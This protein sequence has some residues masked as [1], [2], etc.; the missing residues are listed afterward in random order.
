MVNSGVKSTMAKDKHTITVWTYPT[1]KGH[2]NK[3]TKKTWKNKCPV[4]SKKKTLSLDKKYNDNGV[5]KCTCGAVYCGVSGYQVNNKKKASKKLIPATTTPNSATKVASSQ[6]QSQ[7]CGLKRAT[8]LTKAKAELNTSSTYKGTLKIPILP[9]IRLGGL[10]QLDFAEFPETKGKTLYINSIK[11]DIDNQTYT[12]ELIEGTSHFENKY[13][14]TYIITDKNGKLLTSSSKNPYKAKCSNVNVN[15]GLKDNS[16]ISKKIR[17]KG[18]KLGTVKKCYKW[19]K[20]KSAGGTG[21]WKYK[22]YGNHIVKSEKYNT[23]GE[24]SAEKCWKKKKANCCDFAWLFVML[25]NGA[26]KKVGI[27]KAKYTTLSGKTK[28]HMWNY[29][30][31]KTYD[32]SSKAKTSIDLKKVETIEKDTKTQKKK[33]KKKK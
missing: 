4:C 22:S 3:L 9:G 33:K 23:F 10:I 5:V 13:E 15:I 31:S 14:G 28:G 18:Q 7:I 11:E 24:K 8:A 17:L 26:G 25:C 16:A 19:L 6:T 21:G 12:L 29:K 32:C 20:I 30:G 2:K 27:R 1:K